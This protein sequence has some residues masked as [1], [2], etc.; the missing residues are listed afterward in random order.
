MTSTNILIPC[1]CPDCGSRDGFY[2]IDQIMALASFTGFKHDGS[3]E[4]TGDTEVM[5]DTQEP[6]HPRP[7][8]ECRYCGHSV[9]NKEVM[10]EALFHVPFPNGPYYDYYG[11]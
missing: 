1:R 7:R 9:Y 10:M 8:Y 6:A 4:W 5:W 3:P 11:D 2:E